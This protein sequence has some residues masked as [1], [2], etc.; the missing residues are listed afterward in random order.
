MADV[1]AYSANPDDE[2]VF[3]YTTGSI[4]PNDVVRARV[5]P[6]VTVIPFEA[7]VNCNQLEEVELP[8]GLQTIGKSAFDRC[9]G[10][11]RIKI[12]S[13]VT[14]ISNMAFKLCEKLD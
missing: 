4:V 14:V 13:T 5:H 12:P 3:V 1:H 6:S 11:K 10:L 2:D 7:F 9:K 8:D